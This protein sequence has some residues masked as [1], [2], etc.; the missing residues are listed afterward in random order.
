M[1][2]HGGAE[3]SNHGGDPRGNPNRFCK[4]Q[5]GGTTKKK[6]FGGQDGSGGGPLR[7]FR[8]FPNAQT[9]QILGP[10]TPKPISKLK[11]KKNL[12]KPKIKKSK[13]KS[14]KGF[15]GFY[16]PKTPKKLKK[17]FLWNFFR[18]QII[19]KKKN[20]GK[21]VFKKKKTLKIF[22]FPLFFGAK[23]PPSLSLFSFSLFGPKGIFKKGGP[24]FTK[25]ANP[26]PPGGPGAPPTPPPHPPQRNQEGGVFPPPFPF[27]FS[28]GAESIR[29]LAGGPGGEIYPAS[30]GPTFPF[31]YKSVSGFLPFPPF[32]PFSP[33]RVRGAKKRFPLFSPLPLPPG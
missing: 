28:P 29:S 5:K 23:T 24:P 33:P 4:V 15:R 20:K 26:P 11:K 14:Q 25:G 8:F 13:D 2:Y 1:T 18:A 27:F 31:P 22:P 9:P 12:T 19:R 6:P 21:K 7:S 16:F 17:N 3:N 32:P 10:Q 30:L